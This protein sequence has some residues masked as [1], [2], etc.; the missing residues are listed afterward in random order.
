M[1]DEEREAQLAMIPEL[2]DMPVTDESPVI[3]ILYPMHF[4]QKNTTRQKKGLSHP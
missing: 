1:T 2:T 3:W 4:I